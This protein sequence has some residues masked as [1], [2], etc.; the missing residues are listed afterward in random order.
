MGSG[1]FVGS[2]ATLLF[3]G[4]TILT[5]GITVIYPAAQSIK[6]IESHGKN[7]DKEWLTYWISYG[8]FTLL[9]DFFG[10]L[11]EMIPYF[12]WIKLVFFIFL[13]APQTKGALTI[14]N[15]L[16]EPLLEKYKP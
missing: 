16:V 8:V 13:F 5:L 6:A 3:F 9:D 2:I 11:L 14:Y 4:S 7:D 12:Y 15:N 1:L 10:W